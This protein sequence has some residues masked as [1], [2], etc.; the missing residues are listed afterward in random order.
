MKDNGLT[1]YE[2]MT[3]TAGCKYCIFARL[4]QI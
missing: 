4:L 1:A 2:K 3:R